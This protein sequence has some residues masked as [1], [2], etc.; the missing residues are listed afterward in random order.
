M[1]PAQQAT[2]LFLRLDRFAPTF[3]GAKAAIRSTR[4]TAVLNEDETDVGVVTV[5]K[6]TAGK[7]RFIIT[8]T[9]ENAHTILMGDE[10][11]EIYYP[12]ANEIQQYNL[13][14]YRDVAQKL[15]LL[16]FGTPGRELAANYE[17]RGV[18]QEIIDSQ[19]SEHLE[20]IPKSTEVLKL[21]TRVELWISDRSQCP[22]E[23]KFYFPGGNYRTVLYSDLQLNPVL[24]ASVFDLPKSARRVV[25]N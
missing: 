13:R 9:G 19:P 20:L 16:G 23:Q 22:I 10:K 2:E 14:K 15:F 6:A 25:M 5:K 4:H 7:L 21:L 11:I 1:A 17:V 24:P 8:Y 3:A 18:R 12:K